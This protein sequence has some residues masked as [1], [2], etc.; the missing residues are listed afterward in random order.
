MVDKMAIN[1][2]SID[3]LTESETSSIN[4]ESIENSDVIDFQNDNELIDSSTN[5][6]D[7]SVL[8]KSGDGN[9]DDESDD[10]ESDDGES[11]DGN[12]DESDESEEG[13]ELDITLEEIEEYLQIREKQRMS[14]YF[15][16]KTENKYSLSEAL[17]GVTN[18]VCLLEDKKG[19]K[20]ILKKYRSSDDGNNELKILEMLSE[21]GKKLYPIVKLQTVMNN[22]L[23]VEYEYLEGTDLFDLMDGEPFTKKE[24]KNIIRKLSEALKLA[25]DLDIVHRDLKPENIIINGERETWES[26]DFELYIIDW[27][28]AEI[29]KS[30][31]TSPVN[32]SIQYLAPELVKTNVASKTNDI[33]SL[34]VI[35]YVL[36]TGSSL[37]DSN[38]T[39]SVIESIKL[40]KQD[41]DMDIL[42]KSGCHTLLPS[43]L[44]TSRRRRPKID[45]ILNDPWLL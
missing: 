36:M 25:H 8:N 16:T 28:F 21:Y 45:Q 37:Y 23:W 40:D 4:D 31:K 20:R 7:N 44:N 42:E 18:S 17:S 13:S 41:I 11:D 32:G 43:I 24:V 39:E 2:V 14:G 22:N 33:W 15:K 27:E 9:N 19:N 5:K 38:E 29:I 26:G 30:E 1:D 34:G 35:F 3:S 10:G 12:N 6:Q